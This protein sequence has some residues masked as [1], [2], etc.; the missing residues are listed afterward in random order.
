MKVAAVVTFYMA[1]ALVMVFVN[2]AVLNATPD[3]PLLYLFNQL[4]IAVL[5]LHGASFLTVKV[6]IPKVDVHT[7]KKLTPVVTV[8]II[9]LVF[10]TLCLRGVEAS[11]FQIARGMVLP[12]TILVSC[13]HTYARPSVKVLIAAG[14]VT[15]GFLTGISPN[16]DLPISASPS[17]VS[18][19]YG[20][21]SSLFIAVHA[22]LIKTSL[23]HCN[24]ST[25]ELAYW[26]NLGSA[27]MVAPFIL[28]NGELGTLIHL[29]RSAEWD[30][31]TFGYGSVITGVF[32]FLL[33]VAGLLSIKITSPITHMFSSAA[34]SV[35]QTLLGVWLFGDILTVNRATSILV[36]CGGTMY[37]TWT[38]HLENSSSATKAPQGQKSDDVERGL[39]TIFETKDEIDEGA[40]TPD[41]WSAS[42]KTS[43][44]A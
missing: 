37:Y 35:L 27:A 2:K 16:K 15:F 30:G 3:L 21:L 5:L 32:G 43:E 39:V 38:K 12:L 29:S 31:K 14:I 26:T 18:L 42:R 6:Q 25:I 28:V 19:I 22:V 7:A 41:R 24:N 40:A 8:N 33:C 23:S 10:N 34:R 4:V 1:T 17:V 20:M 44:K 9:G 11:F 36:I 13:I